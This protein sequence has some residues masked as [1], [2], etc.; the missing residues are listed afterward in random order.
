MWITVQHGF[1]RITIIINTKIPL[2]VYNID[3]RNHGQSPWTDDH[4][5]DL[6]SAD[7]KLLFDD[8]GVKNVALLGHSMGG[9]AMMNF[10]FKYVSTKSKTRLTK[11]TTIGH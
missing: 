1:E 9:R 4:N 6:L 3:A 2:Q 7:L 5:Y 8:L 10:S 11:S